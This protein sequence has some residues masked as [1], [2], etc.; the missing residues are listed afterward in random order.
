MGEWKN[1]N[2][3]CGCFREQ[4]CW[5]SH[6]FSALFVLPQLCSYPSKRVSQALVCLQGRAL[7][8]QEGKSL[9][10]GLK[11]EWD[12]KICITWPSRYSSSSSTMWGKKDLCLVS[13]MPSIP[14]VPTPTRFLHP[15][16]ALHVGKN[17]MRRKGCF[18]SPLM[19]RLKGKIIWRNYSGHTLEGLVFY[20]VEA[21]LKGALLML[22]ELDSKWKRTALSR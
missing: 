19:V 4:E 21:V 20:G 12:S 6:F 7:L 11:G 13:I 22:C 17:E 14:L 10:Y 16:E 3:V 8:P 9:N 15:P 18:L 2:C 1:R 5:R